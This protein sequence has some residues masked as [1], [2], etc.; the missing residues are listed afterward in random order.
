M[1][2][3]P[4]LDNIPDTRP[5]DFSYREI[6]RLQGKGEP[7]VIAQRPVE[8]HNPN[9]KYLAHRDQMN[10]G[11]CTGQSA[12]YGAAHNYMKL[13]G[14]IP[15]PDQ[16]SQL[17][18][19]VR[20]SLGSLVDILPPHEFSSECAYQ[21]GRYYGNVTYPSGGDI[22]FVAK[23]MR[24]HGICLESMWHSDKERTCVWMYPP[25]AR[26]T[27][28]GGVTPEEETAFSSLHKIKGWAMVGTPDGDAT[29]DEICQAI[30]E[31]GWVM[32]AI[33]IYTN[34]REIQGQT[35]PVY[36]LPNGEIDG[37]HAQIVDGYSP[38]ALDIEHSW[39]GFCGQHGKLP[40]EY[41]RMARDMCVWLVWL[42]D[43]EVLIAKSHYHTLEIITKDSKTGTP[44][45]A[46]IYVGGVKV[47]VGTQKIACE[48]GKEYT[49]EAKK[50]GYT[51][52]QTV[53]LGSDS[54]QTITLLLD[55]DGT[56]PVKNWFERLI[57][58]IISLFRR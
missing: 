22:R 43:E 1:T 49:I 50:V 33:P 48:P 7:V 26:K 23:S 13:T 11:T 54:D 17:R 25:G 9:Q 15:T 41:Y 38:D 16:L 36:P 47:G 45:D 58:W 24:D 34:Y 10:G 27:D 21:M 28:D 6:K 4:V 29:Y 46:D 37:F 40:Y 55:P 56:A 44:I 39:W 3:E 8:W 30:Y 31:K 53:Y 52:K 12:A 35:V 19:N 51:D 18:R 32:C 14:D 57:E 2:Q 5:H 42:D 20:D